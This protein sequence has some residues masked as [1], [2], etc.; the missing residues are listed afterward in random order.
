MSIA[1]ND[2]DKITYR[3]IKRSTLSQEFKIY[4]I[5][6]N[7]YL[8]IYRFHICIFNDPLPSGL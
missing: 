8:L 2:S 7:Y 6:I 5:F 1:L 4:G 3:S